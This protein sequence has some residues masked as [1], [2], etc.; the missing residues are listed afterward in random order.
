VVYSPLIPI[1]AVF[2]LVDNFSQKMQ[3]LVCKQKIW[4]NVVTDVFFVNG[5]ADEQGRYYT[6]AVSWRSLLLDEN[7]AGRVAL[8]QSVQRNIS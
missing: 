7:R 1:Q 2:V 6:R 5:T 4:K 3:R 8:P